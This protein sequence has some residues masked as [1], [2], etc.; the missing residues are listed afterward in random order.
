[1]LTIIR[2]SSVNQDFLSL[3]TELD[4]E[5]VERYDEKQADLDKNNVVESTRNIVIVYH[6]QVP[7]GCGCYRLTGTGEVE[8]KRMYVIR[9]FR[10]RGISKMILRELEKWAREEGFKT[11]VLE[12]GK[13]QHEA[14]NLYF[15]S[16]Y[17]RIENFPPY[18]G[19][20]MSIC[21]LKN[22]ND[23]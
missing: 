5:L 11:A 17:K 4:R 20:K 23:N 22:L 21:M 12:T 13:K 18:I 9:E 14:M 3:I 19:N 16:D 15:K 8:I 7:V 6:E 1:M 10:G 2:T